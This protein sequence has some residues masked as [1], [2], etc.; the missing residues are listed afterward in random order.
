VLPTP[1][2]DSE[3]YSYARRH[4][5]VLTLCMGL[6]FPPLVYSQI[7]MVENFRW[8]IVYAPFAVF[9]AFCFLLS[10][11]ADGMSRSFDL[12]EHKRIVAAWAPRRYP[13]ADVFLPVCGEPIEVLRNAWS[14][15]AV[16]RNHY[17]VRVTPYVLDDSASPALKAMARHYGF[18]LRHPPGPGLVQEGGQR[19]L[20]VPDLGG[21]VH[22][23]ARRR[24][25]PPTG[26]ARRDAAVPGYVF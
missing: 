13:S 9:G 2:L 26:H 23:A 12:N 21:R 25:R 20:R 14:H 17:P 15:V 24:L 18:R 19:A 6:S 8:F 7:R 22:P 5:W 10:L 4:I 3:K 11:M 16:M 1:P